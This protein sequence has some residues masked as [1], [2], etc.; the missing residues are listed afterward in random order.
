MSKSIGQGFGE[1]S[2]SRIRE[3]VGGV[4]SWSGEQ[5]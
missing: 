2:C 5:E 1:G 3:L 4:G